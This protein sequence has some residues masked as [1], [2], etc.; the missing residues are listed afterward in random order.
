M[1]QEFDFI[2]AY[3]QVAPLYIGGNSFRMMIEER[4][5]KK[6]FIHAEYI[7]GACELVLFFL[8]H[9]LSPIL[10]F[11]CKLGGR[12]FFFRIYDKDI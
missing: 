7:G 10:N 11:K 12:Q 5:I 8:F 3:I 1:H 6:K 9:S 4:E 2:S